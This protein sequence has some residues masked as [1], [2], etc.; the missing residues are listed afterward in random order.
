[1]HRISLYFKNFILGIR[2]PAPHGP[3]SGGPQRRPSWWKGSTQ[4]SPR[5]CHFTRA[6]AATW[7]QR[8]FKSVGN[9]GH[10]GTRHC[11]RRW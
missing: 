10:A 5:N 7:T 6:Q 11:N 8:G 2:S 3:H 4:L 1:M 9:G